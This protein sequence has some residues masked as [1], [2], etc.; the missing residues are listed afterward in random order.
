MPGVRRKE[1]EGVSSIGYRISF[2]GD[3]N[4]LELNSGSGFITL[5]IKLQSYTLFKR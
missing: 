2:W 4:V 3:E 5:Y 1:K